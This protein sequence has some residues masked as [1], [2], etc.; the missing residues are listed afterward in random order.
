MNAHHLLVY[1]YLPTQIC[2]AVHY[3]H[4]KNILHRDLKL[5]NIFV[6]STGVIKLADFGLSCVAF[7]SVDMADAFVGTPF[8][9]RYFV[10]HCSASATTVLYQDHATM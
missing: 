8:Y 6:S 9:F 2:T 5:H 1:S 4:S 7:N 10:L 3:I